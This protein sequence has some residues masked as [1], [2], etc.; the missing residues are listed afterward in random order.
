M[1]FVK[2][3]S[4]GKKQKLSEEEKKKAAELNEKNRAED[5]R[6]VKG[7]FKNLECQGGD[8]E[9]AYHKYKGDPTRIYRFVDGEE[10]EI[11]LGVA[12]HLNQQCKYKKSR[13]LVDADGK[14]IISADKP[15]ERYQFVSTEF[16]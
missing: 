14:R 13:Y 3:V 12:K 8:V 15:V 1:S 5:A 16:M 9:F 10:Y 2:E 7:I 11:P 6:L 4:V